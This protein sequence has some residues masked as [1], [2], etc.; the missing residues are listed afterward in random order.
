MPIFREYS[1]PG[2]ALSPLIISVFVLS[3][4]L[5]LSPSLGSKSV[6]QWFGHMKPISVKIELIAGSM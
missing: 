1:L 6:A 5:S 3:L 2:L 4:S